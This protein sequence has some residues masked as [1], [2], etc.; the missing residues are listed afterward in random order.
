M[1]MDARK[2]FRHNSVLMDKS[3]TKAI[4]WNFEGIEGSGK[5][6]L[7]K[8]LSESLVQ[9]GHEVHHFREPG[10]TSW[11]EGL[12]NQLLQRK[13]EITALAEAHLFCSAR[14]QMLSELIIPL[15]EKQ[16]VIFTDRYYFSSLAY[17]GYGKEL[18]ADVIESL[19]SH[20]PLTLRPHRTLY[21]K[22]SYATSLSRQNQRQNAKDYF[23]QRPSPFFQRAVEGYE[24]IA[25]TNPQVLTLDAELPAS[26]VLNHSLELW[27]QN[28]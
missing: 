28:Q 21:L 4:W 18:G 14:A 9:K 17:Q 23:E 11:G 5:S 8:A 1:D 20:W 27:Q 24:T 26:E 2:F 16:V 6:T 12:R 19:H 22:I 3:P 13:E 10:A 7:I 15:L 25:K